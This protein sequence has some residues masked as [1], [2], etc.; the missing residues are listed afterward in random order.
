VFS[1]D[2]AYDFGHVSQM[3]PMHQCSAC[4]EQHAMGWCRLKVAGVE[5][6]GLCG[7]AHLGHGRTC[8]HLTDER[9][10]TTILQTLKEST[11]SR[12]L[13]EQATKYLRVVRSD[14]VQ[15]RRAHERR[16]QEAIIQ[17]QGQ[18]IAAQDGVKLKPGMPFSALTNGRNDRGR[19]RDD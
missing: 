15:R 6:C 18:A 12:D 2:V 17:R 11:E 5:H 10:V 7:L 16:E 13:V 1:G 14:L 3:P 4:G 19:R 8:P 9:H